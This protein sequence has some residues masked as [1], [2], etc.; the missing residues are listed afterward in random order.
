MGQEWAGPS[1]PAKDLDRSLVGEAM[2]ARR[3]PSSIAHRRLS[4]LVS[5]TKM[6]SSIRE[7]AAISGKKG[8]TTRR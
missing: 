5:T 6:R 2:L 1:R 7:R 4:V 8:T 3:V